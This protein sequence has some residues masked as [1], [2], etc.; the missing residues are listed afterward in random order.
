MSEVETTTTK[1]DKT[2]TKVDEATKSVTTSAPT[3][4]V[5]LKTTEKDMTTAAP[6][7]AVTETTK[8]QKPM[9]V[10]TTKAIS[11][12]NEKSFKSKSEHIDEPIIIPTVTYVKPSKNITLDNN[13]DALPPKINGELIVQKLPSSK[14]LKKE[15]FKKKP[16][17][18]R[19]GTL[20]ATYG[21]KHEK[22][23]AKIRAAATTA[24][25]AHETMKTISNKVVS[26]K[27]EKIK[28]PKK[29]LNNEQ[30]LT[31]INITKVKSDIESKAPKSTKPI[32][33]VKE[34]KE[35]PMVH[36]ESKNVSKTTTQ[37]HISHSETS[38][39]IAAITTSNIKTIHYRTKKPKALTQIKK[40]HIENNETKSEN[41]DTSEIKINNTKIKLVPE[42][43][44]KTLKS[45]NKE[46]H[47]IPPTPI[48]ETSKTLAENPK[49]DIAPEN[50]GGF[51]ILDKSH[52]WELLKEGSN[53][54]PK[55]EDKLQVHS[56]IIQAQNVSDNRSL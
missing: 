36:I 35:I 19:K 28:T 12:W 26:I 54:D 1:V 41:N 46:I 22:F 42:N 7:T 24:T 29:I 39:T 17:P 48:S 34:H 51:E 53:A 13:I 25:Y 9:N 37:P 18:R 27:T 21:D 16:L 43:V 49:T 31:K 56:R 32:K 14:T 40:P 33:Y 38:H 2:T 50:K 6:I 45:I 3:T 23:F 4:I 30:P 5:V 52:I 20:K 44:P 55:I 15:E 11:S 10:L 47:K 8:P